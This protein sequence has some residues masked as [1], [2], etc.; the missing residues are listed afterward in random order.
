L[1]LHALGP[2]PLRPVVGPNSA[3]DTVRTFFICSALLSVVL[4]LFSVWTSLAGKAHNHSQTRYLLLY[5]SRWRDISPSWWE[6]SEGEVSAQSDNFAKAYRESVLDAQK[7]GSL[8]D[9]LQ[10]QCLALAAVLF[11]V[12]CIGWRATGRHQ[13]I[14]TGIV[15]PDG[16]ANRSQ[17]VGPAAN[18]GSPAAGSR[19]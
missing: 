18:Q 8:S 7:L 6:L 15:Q 12:S 11:V 2:A 5:D 14:E 3:C 4:G 17:P 16:S 9:R 19:R 13:R 10:S 1:H